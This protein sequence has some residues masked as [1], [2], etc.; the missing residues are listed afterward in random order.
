[1][2]TFLV[3]FRLTEWNLALTASFISTY[4]ELVCEL[5]CSISQHFRSELIA[6]WGRS[7]QLRRWHRLSVVDPAPLVKTAAWSRVRQ[8]QASPPFL[9]VGKRNEPN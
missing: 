3:G 6:P 2:P 7:I 9:R 5:P 4:V 8:V 1:M